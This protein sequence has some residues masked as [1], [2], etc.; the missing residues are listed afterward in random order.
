MSGKGIHTF[1]N[2]NRFEGDY[3]DD[4]RSIAGK[5]VEGLKERTKLKANGKGRSR[6]KEVTISADPSFF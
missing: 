1:P 2:G 5:E 4:M 6:K 3:I